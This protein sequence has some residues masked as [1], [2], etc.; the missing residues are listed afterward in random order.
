MIADGQVVPARTGI[1][2]AAAAGIATE[3]L[4]AE[5]DRVQ[6]N[7]VVARLD[8]SRHKAAI[9]QAEAQVTVAEAK[10][11]EMKAGPRAQEVAVY[12]ASLAAAQAS[13]Q[14]LRE[15]PDEAQLVAARAEVA[16]ATAALAQ[17]QAAYD[18]VKGAPD[19]GLRPESLALEQATNTRDAAQARLD[20]LQKPASAA[21]IAAANADIRRAQAQLDL[22]KAGVRSEAISIAEAELKVA[23]AQLEQ[24]KVNLAET[25]LRAP[26]SG[27]VISLDVRPGEY[28]SPGGSILRLAD[29]T[30]WSIETEDVTELNVVSIREGDAVTITFEAIRDLQLT[31]RVTRIKP[32]G[33]NKRGDIIYTVILTPDRQDERLRWNMSA[34]IVFQGK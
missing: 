31:G 15:G 4:V 5:G 7:Q 32:V 21:A 34:S 24:A 18:K 22:V 26:I 29:L 13:L 1:V 23:R 9:A 19:I 17:A 20:A 8:A 28:V 11:A 3:V 14:K 30:T 6:A 25:E 2:S 12:E 10:V 16:N 27:T 33:E